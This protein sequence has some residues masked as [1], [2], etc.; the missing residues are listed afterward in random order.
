MLKQLKRM[1]SQPS[2]TINREIELLKIK[3]RAITKQ[4][5]KVL[6]TSQLKR[7]LGTSAV[8][9]GIAFSNPVEAQ[10]F[11]APVANPFGLEASP[12]AYFIAPTIADLDGDGDLDILIGGYEEYN[13]GV[14][15]Y[16]ENTG[17]TTEPA[18]AAPVDN[19][20]GIEP[21]PTYLNS[22]V[23]ADLDGDG[24][25]DILNG[26]A[27]YDTDSTNYR[28]VF[29]YE[30]IG[31][32]TEPSFAVPEN[33][34]FNL[35]SENDFI[36]P[37]LADID[38]DGDLDYLVALYENEATF[39][40]FQ[41]NISEGSEIQF[42]EIENDPFSIIFSDSYI[43]DLS[44]VDID[45]DGDLDLFM[46]NA[47]SETNDELGAIYYQENIGTNTE[48]LF[49]KEVEAN[50]FGI[51][52]P[53]YL[54]LADFADMDGDGDMDMLVGGYDY[55]NEVPTFQYFENITSPLS[56]KNISS[57]LSIEVFPN[58]ANDVIQI[59]A[60][61]D[62]ATIEIYNTLGQLVIIENGNNNHLSVNDLS[63]GMYTI[64]II[65]DRGDFGISKFQKL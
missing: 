42:G 12:N 18:F 19:P 43:I 31:T 64:K 32:A 6:P 40:A 45:N 33:K 3:I 55:I 15:K 27:Y 39:P 47:Y 8:L 50:P 25:Y 5:S 16:Y 30:N 21:I 56:N 51:Q 9:L 17:T 53:N 34:P 13:Y 57:T 59:N 1:M 26:S 52:T 65:S 22:P 10:T 37:E 20:F 4:L 44:V 38:G 14:L 29:Y 7:L 28:G 54:P 60:E 62:I 63:T 58:P 41:E 24:D 49:S 2:S 35:D 36:F 11:K 61:M 23:L 46:S 48:P